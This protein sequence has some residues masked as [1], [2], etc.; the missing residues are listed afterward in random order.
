M[1]SKFFLI[2]KNFFSGGVILMTKDKK[3]SCINDLE[4]RLDLVYDQSCP[5]V[6]KMLFSAIKK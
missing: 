6:K 5:E 3:I 1:F 4:A 2:I